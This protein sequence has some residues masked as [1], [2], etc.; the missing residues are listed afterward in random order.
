MIDMGGGFPSVNTL[1][2]PYDI[3]GGSSR[4]AGYLSP[5]AE[6]ICSRL[7]NA[8]ELFGGRPTL[9][10]EPGRAIVDAAIQLAC[11]VVAKKD[12]PGQGSAVIVDAGT[13][14]VPTAC[15][16]DHD[17]GIVEDDD[18]QYRGLLRPVSIYGPL[19][20]QSDM[21][22]EQALLPPVEIGEPLVIS[23]VGA[24]CHTQSSQFIQPR[25]ATVLL[26]PNGPE[27]I[28][29]RETWRDIFA[30]DQ[31]PRRLRRSGFDI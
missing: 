30:L 18:E 9:V 4:E 1:K 21:L 10:L 19:C 27:L 14:L 24:Y 22:R 16:Y 2:A 28:R 6:T 23:N 29:R 31:M 12:I 26:G 13:N 7:Q 8:S 15:Y 25:P 3:P 17:I 5:Y 11:T 20:M